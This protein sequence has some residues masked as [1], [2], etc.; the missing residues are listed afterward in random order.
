MEYPV[1]TGFFQYANARLA[2]GWLW[3][4]ERVR[5]CRPALPVVVYF[6]L[7]ALWL[8]LAWLVVVW[9]VRALRPARP[10]DAALVALSPLVAVHAFTNFDTL[11]VACATGGLLALARRH[12][13]LAG[14]LI[15]V[16]GAFKFY[17]LLLLLPVLVV[18]VRRRD[19]GV[20]APDRRRP[21]VLT[22]V[23]LNAPIALAYPAGLVGVLPAQPDPPGRPRLALLRDQL[24]QRLGRASTARWPPGRPR[25]C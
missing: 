8:A 9:A 10:W 7:S 20:A 23:A 22:W 12:P 11:A 24:L 14:L 21:R 5:W 19:L 6:D 18:A 16:G 17:P 15:G 1:L 3:L 2:D 13:L 4:A 25:R